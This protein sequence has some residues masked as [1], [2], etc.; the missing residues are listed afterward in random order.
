MNNQSKTKQQLQKENYALRGRIS[1]LEETVTK[2]RHH[3]DGGVLASLTDRLTGLPNR[4]MFYDTLNSVLSSA[5]KSGDK[6]AIIFFSIDRFK[7]IND[8]LGQNVGDMLLR[9]VAARL[10]KC[11]RQHDTLCRPGRDEFLILLPQV[12]N[13]D[14]V[15]QVAERIFDS[16][17]APFLLDIH[18]FLIN[19]N[20]GICLYPEG[21][22]TSDALIRNAYAALQQA[23][24]SGKNCYSFFSQQSYESEF[25]RLLL[26]NDLRLAVS[27]L[28]FSLHYQPQVDLLDGRIIGVEA[29]TRWN[30]TSLGFIPPDEFIPLAEE[31]GLMMP[32]G[33]CVIRTS[34]DHHMTFKNSGCIPIRYAVNL[35]PT[36]LYSGDLVSGVTRILEET[37]LEPRYLELEITEGALLKNHN[38]TI[39]ALDALHSCGVQISIDD[40]GTGYSSLAYLSQFSISKLKIDKSFTAAITTDTKCEAISRAIVCLA[41]SLDIRVMA[42][43]VET[44]EQLD[45]LRDLG[46]DEIQGYLVSHPMPA[47]E[48]A[49]FLAGK[50]QII[51]P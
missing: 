13:R 50:S 43:G 25:S 1:L 7:L 41:H 17:A 39:Y 10:D 2:L 49:L 6:L 21:G 24:E 8:K 9:M 18:N 46:C 29:L 28:D 38:S 23:K 33:D 44:R 27:R 26:E 20:I 51:L 35:S 3:D 14:S 30:H 47:D 12:H 11:L 48:T 5:R 4:T 31:I 34:C 16:L 42:E 15:I 19:S 40:F 45:F 22:G 37:G 36:Q 32:L